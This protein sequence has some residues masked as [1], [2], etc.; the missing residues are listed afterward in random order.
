M[1][2]YER[3]VEI[4]SAFIYSGGGRRREDEDFPIPGR[5]TDVDIVIGAPPPPPPPPV[6]AGP[7]VDGVCLLLEVEPAAIPS[8]TVVLLGDR[9]CLDPDPLFNLR[10]LPL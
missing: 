6:I 1:R 2:A 9:V 7:L 4:P 10:V 3:Q 8:S 5:A